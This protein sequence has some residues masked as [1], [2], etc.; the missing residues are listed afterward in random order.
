M[1]AFDDSFRELIGEEGELSTDRDDPGNWTSGVVDRGVFKGTKYGISAASYPNLDIAALTL[2]QAKTIAK[3]DFWDRVSGDALPPA[4]AHA[5]FDC[6]YNQ[7][8]GSA[9]R[10]LQHALGVTEDGVIGP[11]TLSAFRRSD[12][13]GFARSFT[14]A[15]IV[16]YSMTRNWAKNAGGWVGRALDAYAEMLK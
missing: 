11:N 16:R 7:G 13:P 9:I 14:V 2:D 1:S 4:V 12:V 8:V 6:A 5:L 3:Q 10:L 15:R